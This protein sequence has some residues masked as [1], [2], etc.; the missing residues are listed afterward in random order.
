M[1]PARYATELAG[2]NTK[3]TRMK[4]QWYTIESACQDVAA[5][6]ANRD[7]YSATTIRCTINDTLH[8]WNRDGYRVYFGYSQIKAIRRVR[9]ILRAGGY[10][11]AVGK[12]N[13]AGR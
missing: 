1:G 4:P 9:A 7:D 12:G 3:G 5:A 10:M 8:G 11:G 2:S 6:L 13:G